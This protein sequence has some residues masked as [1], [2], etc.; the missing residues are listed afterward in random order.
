MLEQEKQEELQASESVSDETK[1]AQAQVQ[2]QN[3]ASLQ[4]AEL[5]G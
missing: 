3:A 4:S 5:M 2:F 1:P